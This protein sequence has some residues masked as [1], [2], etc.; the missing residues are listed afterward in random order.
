MQRREAVIESKP[1]IS[2][3]RRRG[4]ERTTDKG[5]KRES[6]CTS[7]TL[8]LDDCILFSTQMR[9]RALQK[10]LKSEFLR[11]LFVL[12]ADFH[13][14]QNALTTASSSPPLHRSYFSSLPMEIRLLIL[15][16]VCNVYRLY[17]KTEEQK[18][19]CASFIRKEFS[20][21]RLIFSSGRPVC[22][23]EKRESSSS[24]S[25][26]SL[27]SLSSPTQLHTFCASAPSLPTLS[28]S[29]ESLSK[30]CLRPH[31]VGPA[32]PMS[33]SASEA[34]EH[35]ACQFV[36]TYPPGL[37]GDLNCDRYAV[38]VFKNW[39]VAVLSEGTSLLSASLSL[40]GHLTPSI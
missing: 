17:G 9:N 16:A 39:T 35:F 26:S 20:Q 31:L 23:I 1:T 2:Q 3:R 8:L 10:E 12:C 21:I 34:T 15:R 28:I 40:L 5:P 13:S 29:L 18:W 11:V 25:S 36:N 24:S 7:L 37:G 27:F 4:G 32:D 22:L 33:R 14:S 30:E 19:Q 6:W 38:A